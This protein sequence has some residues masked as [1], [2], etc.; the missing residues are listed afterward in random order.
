MSVIDVGSDPPAQGAHETPAA[1]MGYQRLEEEEDYLQLTTDRLLVDETEQG[2]QED[3]G[4]EMDVTEEKEKRFSRESWEFLPRSYKNGTPNSLSES[5]YESIMMDIKAEIERL[6]RILTEGQ[7]KKDTNDLAAEILSLKDEYNFIAEYAAQSAE[8][9]EGDT[10]KGVVTEKNACKEVSDDEMLKLQDMLRFGGCSEDVVTEILQMVDDHVK[11]DEEQPEPAKEEESVKE[12]DLDQIMADLATAMKPLE[13]LQADH[14]P[15]HEAADLNIAKKNS[16]LSLQI[17]SGEVSPPKTPSP[18]STCVDHGSFCEHST[19]GHSEPTTPGSSVPNDSTLDSLYERN[20]E[21]SDN[22]SLGDLLE[23]NLAH[24]NRQ[25]QDNNKEPPMHANMRQK[26]TQK[27]NGAM[28]A[29]VSTDNTNTVDTSEPEGA[30]SQNG[31]GSASSHV[32]GDNSPHSQTTNND[33]STSD[34]LFMEKAL[35][36]SIF[37]NIGKPFSNML[38]IKICILHFAI[39]F[40]A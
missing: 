9:Q 15:K 21:D 40:S 1:H 32:E 18:L 34:T 28:E 24:I 35:L 16:G 36:E 3:S 27:V 19:P 4:D 31:H 37:S 14:I 39:R 13:A 38:E 29:V 11:H 7:V 26:G 33:N 17:P 20:K 6:E 30:V 23:T 25:K 8:D 10:D 22:D 12:E 5:N 2:L